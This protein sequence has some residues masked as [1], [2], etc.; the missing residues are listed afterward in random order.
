MRDV[1]YI[2]QKLEDGDYVPGH[3]Q[4]VIPATSGTGIAFKP[5]IKMCVAC[6]GTGDQKHMQSAVGNSGESTRVHDLKKVCQ[7]CGGMG[8]T[9][10]SIYGGSE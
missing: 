6:Q 7:K 1:K 9:I 3:G 10:K 5:D 8:F 4:I 2:G